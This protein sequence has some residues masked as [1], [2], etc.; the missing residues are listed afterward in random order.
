MYTE[1]QQ[2]GEKDNGNQLHSCGCWLVLA[3]F[4]LWLSSVL[5]LDGVLLE[6]S[7]SLYTGERSNSDVVHN[8]AMLPHSSVPFTFSVPSICPSVRLFTRNRRT[9]SQEAWAQRTG[10]RKATLSC[11]LQEGINSVNNLIIK[12]Y[13][14]TTTQSGHL[15]IWLCCVYLQC[16][17]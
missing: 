12:L 9:S 17:L 8:D 11:C 7:I 10:Y 13:S 14:F 2:E 1:G 4:P 16:V 15:Q 3:P 6:G 5:C